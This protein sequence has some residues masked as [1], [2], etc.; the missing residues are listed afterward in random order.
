[1]NTKIIELIEKDQLKKKVI[2]FNV[3]DSIAVHNIID[4]DKEG[5]ERV[6]IFKGIV[7]RIKGAGLAKTFTIRKI[8][9]AGI[10]VEKIFPLNSPMIKKIEFIKKGKVRRAKIYYM[11]KRIGKSALKILEGTLTQ[12]ELKEIEDAMKEDEILEIVVE[13]PV[14]EKNASEEVESKQENMVDEVIEKKSVK[15]NTSKTE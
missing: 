12:G 4:K 6:Q 9:H 2:N 10:G 7:L 15:E 13:Q 3:G 11:R 1:M 14:V 5:K 8:S